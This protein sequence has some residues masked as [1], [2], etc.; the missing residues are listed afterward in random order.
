MVGPEGPVFGRRLEV[1]QNV[2][3]EFRRMSEEGRLYASEARRILL[4]VL[5]YVY[6]EGR[7]DQYSET[8]RPYCRRC[9]VTVPRGWEYC[10]KCQTARIEEGMSVRQAAGSAPTKPEG[11][12]C[13]PCK[14][15][16]L[17]YYSGA[18]QCSIC[19]GAG[20]V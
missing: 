3:A 2:A 6:A 20:G 14:V 8:E 17:A 18:L 1:A 19:K 5:D 9:N 7:A 16:G 10:E 4:G 12:R 13:F 11:L 15:T